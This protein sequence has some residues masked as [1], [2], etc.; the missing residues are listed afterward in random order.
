MAQDRTVGPRR[1]LRVD[2]KTLQVAFS[3][4]S[5]ETHY[6]LDRKTGEVALVTGAVRRQLEDIYDELYRADDHALSRFENA[7]R[8]RHLPPDSVQAVRQAHQIECGLGGRYTPLPPA[9][10]HMEVRDMEDYIPT[11]QDETLREALWNALRSHDPQR[12]FMEALSQYPDLPA[13]W[14]EFHVQQVVSRMRHWLD[15]EGIEP[16]E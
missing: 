9:H 2:L 12:R 7:L 8:L 14:S 15:E 6:F 16:I 5:F 13:R 11:V 1:K 3:D 4:S 10:P